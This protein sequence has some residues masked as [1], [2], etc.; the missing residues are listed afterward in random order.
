MENF[1]SN[2]EEL[3]NGLSA[4]LGHIGDKSA[5]A[6]KDIIETAQEV[7]FGRSDYPQ[8]QQ[9]II[10]KYGNHIITNIKIGRT[11]L[12]SWITTSINILSLGQFQKIFNR[13]PY[14]DLYHLFCILTLE[15]GDTI[16]MLLE[17]NEAINMRVVS[18]YNPKNTD[19]ITV[20]QIP[21][22]LSFAELLNNTRDIQKGRFF[23]YNA[24]SNNCQDFIIDM[25]KGSRM[26]TSDL[27]DFVKQ[28]VATLFKKLPRTKSAIKKLTDLGGAVDIIKKGIFK[29]K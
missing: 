13:S 20:E 2:Q 1:K 4:R 28:D 23:K 18:G 22:D 3:T 15:N 27:T 21:D 10:D 16:M 17:K 7:I 14:D 6:K 25:L 9:K 5:T 26:L 12:P 24:V 29:K 8:D 11:P 19:Y